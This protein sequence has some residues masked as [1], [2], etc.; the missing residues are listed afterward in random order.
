M[1]LLIVHI[2]LTYCDEVTAWNI[3]T[4]G[5][6]LWTNIVCFYRTYQTDYCI[7]TF[8]STNQLT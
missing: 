6:I 1:L 5:N 7:S 3:I 2:D 8:R 4:F